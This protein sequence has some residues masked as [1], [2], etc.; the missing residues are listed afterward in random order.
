M[1]CYRRLSHGITLLLSFLIVSLATA[2]DRIVS[3]T[4][5]LILEVLSAND[6]E[7]AQSQG[8]LM[9]DHTLTDLANERAR[10][11]AENAR[12]E[13]GVVLAMTIPDSIASLIDA[14]LLEYV[15]EYSELEGHL[16]AT[17]LEYHDSS[18]DYQIT[19][20]PT[21]ASE[22]VFLHFDG[23]PPVLPIGHLVR[24][25]GTLLPRLDD[26]TESAARRMVVS[27]DD[28]ALEEVITEPDIIIAPPA[29]G[30]QRTGVFVARF[31]DEPIFAAGSS[32]DNEWRKLNDLVRLHSMGRSWL[33]LERVGN[34]ELATSHTCDVQLIRQHIDQTLAKSNIDIIKYDRVFVV[35]PTLECEWRTHTTFP[36]SPTVVVVSGEPNTK[37]MLRAFLNSLGIPGHFSS[38]CEYDPIHSECQSRTESEPEYLDDVNAIS[39]SPVDKESLGWIGREQIKELR[40]L[41]GGGYYRIFASGYVNTNRRMALKFERPAPLLQLE[42]TYYIEYRTTRTVH[43]E[44]LESEVVVYIVSGGRIADVVNLT[45]PKPVSLELQDAISVSVG[46]FVDHAAGLEIE[47]VSAYPRAVDLDI[48][49]DPTACVPAAPDIAIAPSVTPYLSAESTIRFSLAITSRDSEQCGLTRPTL[50]LQAP[51]GWTVQQDRETPLLQPGDTL[52]MD[53]SVTI[54]PSAGPGFHDLGWTV[55]GD[56][57]IG[58]HRSTMLF[59]MPHPAHSGTDYNTVQRKIFEHVG[60]AHPESASGAASANITYTLAQSGA[61]SAN[62]TYTL[63]QSG[64]VSLAVYDANGKL[65]RTLLNAQQQSA[66]SQ[67][68]FWDGNGDD[69]TA[70][71]DGTYT[72]KLLQTQGLNAELITILGSTV[73]GYAPGVTLEHPWYPDLENGYWRHETF[74]NHSGPTSITSDETGIYLAAGISEVAVE[75]VKI[76]LDGETRLWGANQPDAWIGRY[77]MDVMDDK[78][79][80][81]GQDAYVYVHDRNVPNLLS[82]AV[83]V[84]PNQIGY[85][86]DALFPGSERLMN[87]SPNHWDG[88]PGRLG[89]D[90]R[91][92]LAARNV[93]GT[94]HLV[95]S[96]LDHNLVQ[97]RDPVTGAVLDSVSVPSPSG[98][99]VDTNGNVL[100]VSADKIYRFSRS[101]KTVQTV[102]SGLTSPWRIAV[103]SRNNEI[104]VTE[105]GTSQQIKRLSS[106]GILLAT[107]GRL[108]GRPLSGPY[109]PTIGFFELVD[110]DAMQ[111]GDILVVEWGTQVAPRR[112]VRLAPNGTFLRE[113]NGSPSWTKQIHPDPDDPTT[114]WYDGGGAHLIRAKVDYEAKTWWIDATF[115]TLAPF[116]VGYFGDED[117]WGYSA[118]HDSWHV[119]K[120]NGQTYFLNDNNNGQNLIMIARLDE[121]AGKVKLCTAIG[122]HNE[123]GAYEKNLGPAGDGIPDNQAFQWVD[124]NGDGEAQ[125][126]E[127]TSYP[128][129]TFPWVLGWTRSDSNFSFVGSNQGDG[130]VYLV[131]VVGWSA[132]GCPVY[133]DLK[134][135]SDSPPWGEPLPSGSTTGKIWPFVYRS[136]SGEVYSVINDNLTAWGMP[137]QTH[138]AKW[139]ADGNL[140]WMIKSNMVANPNDDDYDHTNNV[141]PPHGK[142]YAFRAIVGVTS[143]G[144]VVANDYQGGWEGYPLP[145]HYAWDKDGLWVGGLFEPGRV[146]LAAAD[147][148]LYNNGSDNL[149]GALWENATTGDIYFYDVGG[150]G[151]SNP[152]IYKITGWNNWVRMS[153]T[154][155]GATVPTPTA[156]LSANPTSI[157]SGQSSTLSWSSTDATSC[158]GVNFSTGGA[159]AESVSV[160]PIQTTTYSLSCSGAGGSASDS[161]TVTVTPPSETTA[162]VISNISAS[163]L[164]G[165]YDDIRW[166]V[167]WATNE[168]SDSLVRYGTSAGNLSL[169]VSASAL[170]LAHAL[171]IPNLKRKTTIY[172]TVT[173]KDAAGNSATSPVQSFTTGGRP[174]KAG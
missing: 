149:V 155:G 118:F 77:S 143:N 103:D 117:G 69:G 52:Q 128:F 66:G 14:P 34:V 60:G 79:F 24:V 89:T 163:D 56:A 2:D 139:K 107:Y 76:S 65:V 44:R 147:R 8:S 133:R 22:T 51:N 45:S 137:T 5:A 50:H 148:F 1:T 169:S 67:S 87:G 3:L 96:Y 126:T 9:A 132:A 23:P 123:N 92:D 94:S 106:A 97:W 172:Y 72:W 102:A 160:S 43:A 112:M 134:Q 119:R 115:R 11:L 18:R 84:G 162:P 25:R 54:P 48:S 53:V 130:R 86:F 167:V 39:I 122:F 57:P 136:D 116:Q 146:D 70:L 85:R 32:Y 157:S 16:T 7:G 81:L 35:L 168:R 165:K 68:V 33:S 49:F 40:I 12:S 55:Q 99:E 171:E 138:V 110:I 26:D 114:V 145:I 38:S 37:L 135:I 95:L 98:I 28:D 17:S 63:A 151:D 78:L 6:T 129:Q 109:D 42:T 41:E 19:L 46:R 166:K 64:R 82:Q 161:A 144:S 31:S 125:S 111:N 10:A 74:G 140:A 80:S 73:P 142:V 21:D 170:V 90:Q 59:V 93:G 62:I 113:W 20:Q 153:G 158:T 127:W 124:Q 29:V 121:A 164:G 27:S 47:V 120:H 104:L 141:Q 13:S 83:G 58:A 159:V 173:S 75:A 150:A 152:R 4:E 131:D 154:V 108:G 36:G 105:R 101:N 88:S 156:S 174:P 100:V 71:P 61:A 91:M 15:E 30:I